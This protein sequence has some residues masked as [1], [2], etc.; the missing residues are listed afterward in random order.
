L[1][2]LSYWRRVANLRLFLTRT[3]V[4]FAA[5]T[6][7]AWDLGASEDENLS[8]GISWFTFLLHPSR[9]QRAPRESFQG[10]IFQIQAMCVDHKALRGYV[11]CYAALRELSLA[12]AKFMRR[13]ERSRRS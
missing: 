10:Q 4:Q 8:A 13:G 12:I 7:C 9:V 5:E 1:L 3:R 11:R 2:L 6:E